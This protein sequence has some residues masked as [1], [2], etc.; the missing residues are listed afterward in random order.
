MAIERQFHQEYLGRRQCFLLVRIRVSSRWA[1]TRKFLDLARQQI[2]LTFH[3]HIFYLPFYFQ[4]VKGTTAEGSGIRTIPYLASIIASSIIV[5]A[6]ITVIGWYKPFMIFGSAVFTVGA[7]MLYTLK[8]NSYTGKWVGYQLLSGFGAG[9]GVQIPFIAVQ[10]VLGA[11]VF[12]SLGGAIAIS[13][14]QN[15]FSNGLYKNLPLYAP[16]VPPK[17]VIHSGATYLRQVISAPD[18][19]GVLNAYMAALTDA[20]VIP[21]TVGGIATVCACFVEWKSVKGKNIIPAAA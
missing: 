5:G 19:P 7:G 11:K 8:V 4:A 2:S 6:G 16:T 15:V 1:F 20:Y 3:R 9:A 17:L 18:L 21:I 10:V 13:I 12:N 14:A